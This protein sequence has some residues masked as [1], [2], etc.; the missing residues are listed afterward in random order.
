MLNCDKENK[1]GEVSWHIII[2]ISVSVFLLI[3]LGIVSFLCSRKYCDR[4]QHIE[5]FVCTKLNSYCNLFSYL[6][7]QM[8]LQKTKP[9]TRQVTFNLQ[10]PMLIEQL[11]L[12]MW[13]VFSQP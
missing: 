3:V 11:E 2:A 13:T 12:S 7:K 10:G 4:Y 8:L 1:N 5:I 9:I 6:E